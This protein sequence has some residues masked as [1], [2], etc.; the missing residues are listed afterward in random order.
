[1]SSCPVCESPDVEPFLDLGKVPVFCNVQWDTREQALNA[2]QATLSLSACVRCGHVFNHA[3]DESVLAYSPGYDNTQHFSSTFQRYAEALVDRLI[4]THGV[5]GKTVVDIGCGRGDLLKLIADRGGNRGYGFDPSYAGEAAETS[6]NVTMSREYFGAKQA[7]ELQPHLV[8]LRHVLEHV[9]NPI[10]FLNTMREALLAGSAP[11]LYLE[12]PNGDHLLKSCG[13]W[14]YIYEHVSYFSM[15]SLRVSLEKAGFEILTMYEDFGGQFLCA[16]LRPL[17]QP[18]Q[19]RVPELPATSRQALRD[20]GAAMRKKLAWWKQW[21][22]EVT[23]SQRPVTVWGAGSKGV[24][25]LNLMCPPKSTCVP[26]IV[27]QSPGKSGR[28]IAGT[29]HMVVAPEAERLRQVTQIVLMNSIYAAEVSAR[30]AAAQSPA[31]LISADGGVP[32][33]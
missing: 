28:F 8:C 14:D 22:N 26:H 17:A 2:P 30:L 18:R 12:V 10:A 1:V 19:Y 5:R 24:T 11:V 9:P 15:T 16:D 33:S 13:V 27:D 31:R 6:S 7:K 25:F 32:A 29:G 3:F 20:A 23:Q 21:A 4:A